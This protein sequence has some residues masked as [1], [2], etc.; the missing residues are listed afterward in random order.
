M[1][2]A[3]ALLDPRELVARPDLHPIGV[4]DD[5]HPIAAT[6]IAEMAVGDRHPHRR[7]V[8]I[9]T[10][11]QTPL[12]RRRRRAEPIKRV[13]IEQHVGVRDVRRRIDPHQARKPRI[14]ER[15][16]ARPIGIQPIDHQPVKAQV[17]HARPQIRAD[18]RRRAGLRH[19]RHHR[20]L[21]ATAEAAV[22]AR[23]QMDHV[24]SLRGRIH[25]RQIRRGRIQV[26]R[27]RH[28]GR[29]QRRGREG[30][31]AHRQ[32]GWTK[33]QM[34]GLTAGQNA[35]LYGVL[36]RCTAADRGGATATGPPQSGR[37]QTLAT[38]ESTP[39]PDMTPA[40][41]GCCLPRCP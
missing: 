16:V 37:T 1:R 38:R 9:A 34:G 6:T 15:H 39:A 31:K 25:A 2:R 27:R 22:V 30:Q 20:R 40:W 12:I 33:G 32:R 36:T 8:V 10:D 11:R 3:R 7:A 24:A 26:R 4:A 13:A 21:R 5:L 23:R 35:P 19:E 41:G 29:E 14:H 18:R 28:P 17:V